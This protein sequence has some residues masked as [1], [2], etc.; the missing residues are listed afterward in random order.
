MAAQRRRK[1]RYYANLPSPYLFNG[2]AL[3]LN[4]D[5]PP[6]G[7]EKLFG[8]HEEVWPLVVKDLRK[9]EQQAWL[10]AHEALFHHFGIRSSAPGAWR[11]LGLSLAYRHER[12][13]LV[14][15]N[16]ICYSALCEKYAVDPSDLEN[17]DHALVRLLSER[18]VWPEIE[19]S[20]KKLDDW[21]TGW[22]TEDLVRLV[23]AIFAVGAG[24]K[25][26]AHA[27]ADA[28]RDPKALPRIIGETAAATIRAILLKHGNKDK[29]G[30]RVSS[31]SW[32]RKTLIPAVLNPGKRATPLQEQLYF[33]VLPLV[34]SM[35]GQIEDVSEC[36]K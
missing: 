35:A 36:P 6:P 18:H 10:L 30:S 21:G 3:A 1:R 32:V 5:K 2:S 16:L 15:G 31:D 4:P 8:F 13:L 23:L 14:S 22:S 33:D 34:W 29:G 24:K 17:A 28:L 20:T 9:Q 27:I 25:A 11:D 12:D 7:W 19:P 26:S